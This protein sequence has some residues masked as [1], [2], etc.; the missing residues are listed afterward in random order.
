MMYGNIRVRACLVDI[1]HLSIYKT[2]FY[3][4]SESIWKESRFEIKIME[5]NETHFVLER[6]KSSL[7]YK[8]QTE[9]F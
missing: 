3:A 6:E 4:L 5:I 2:Q 7:Y 8:I 9:I 1:C